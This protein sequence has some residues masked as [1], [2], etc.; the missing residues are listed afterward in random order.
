MRKAPEQEYDAVF[1]EMKTKYGIIEDYFS[2]A[3]GIDVAQQQ[4][5]RE[6]YLEQ[7]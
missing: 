4:A 1:D 3:L 5:I 6:I 2:E 7:K